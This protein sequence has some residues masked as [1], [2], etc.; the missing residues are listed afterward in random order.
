MGKALEIFA[1]R[2]KEL[3]DDCILVILHNFGLNT[4]DG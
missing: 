2:I 1:A 4:L 3:R